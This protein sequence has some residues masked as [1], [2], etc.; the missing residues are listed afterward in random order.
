MKSFDDFL[1]TITDDDYNR[2]LEQS[3]DAVK[4]RGMAS[5]PTNFNDVCLLQTVAMLRKYHQWLSD[6]L[7]L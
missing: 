5:T 1:A 7:N 3:V 6:Q 2:M 4:S